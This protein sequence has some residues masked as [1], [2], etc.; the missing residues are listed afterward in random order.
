MYTADCAGFHDRS[1]PKIAQVWP[2][3]LA[4]DTLKDLFHADDQFLEFFKKNRAQIDRSFF[5]FLSDHGPRAESIGKTRLGRYE[6]LN[7]FLMVLI[8]SVYRDTPIHLQLR[9]KTYEL[10][11]NFDL[12][13]TITDILKIQPAAGYTDTSYRDLMPLSKGSSLLR[14]WRGP[15][16]CRTLPIPSQYCICQYKETNVS[17][18][19][20][21]ENLGWFF[22][23]QFNKHLFNHGLSDK[24]QMQSFNSTASGR[25]IK[26]GLST[27]YDMV[28]YL[29]PSGEMLL[30]EAHIRSN[31]SGLT[32]SSGF[33]RLD[34]YGRQGDCLVGNTLRSLCHCKGTTVPPVL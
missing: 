16:N 19:T 14:E 31:S 20:L 24:C 23:D 21:T 34:R 6:G 33:T 11:T 7:P 22:A 9:Q 12:H 1:T 15:R 2:T 18:E 28:V 26:D 5:F 4:H 30:F 10:M 25:K 17:Q 29:V 8:P 3:S 27:L 13:A 32:L